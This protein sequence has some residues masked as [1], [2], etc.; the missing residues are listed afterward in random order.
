MTD[1]SVIIPVYNAE[2]YLDA[3]IESIL[4]QRGVSIE[5]FLVD[6]GS[7]DSSGSIC[8]NYS[9]KYNNI[10]VVHITNSGQSVARNTGLKL[11]HGR[12]VTFTDND[13]K[14]LPEMLSKMVSAGDN[15]NADIICCNYNEIDENGVISHNEST[16]Q[17]YILNH[18]EALV[19]FYS[20]DKIY[21]QC[22]SKLYRRQM[23]VDFHVENDPVRYDEDIIF[24]IKA[25]RVAQTTV[26]VDEPLFL[27]T[28]RTDSVVHSHWRYKKYMDRY[29][30]D[31]IKRLQ[32]TAESVQ[33]ESEQV[34]GWAMV[35]MLMY[36]NQLIGRVAA[37]PEYHSDKRIVGAIHFIRKNKT[38]LNR[39]YGRCG[40]S[41]FG[42]MLIIYLPTW[43][44]MKYRRNKIK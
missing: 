24:N 7:T 32:L 35:H 43:L 9:N 11:A 22:W 38:I 2:K 6:D 37:F 34:K 28:N 19:H 1:V 27:Y 14:M 17:E 23:L 10:S 31:N 4:Q 5:I 33:D 8:D 21:S 41:K 36:Y 26:I 12:Y 30:N 15:H 29:I 40:F 39:Y 44:Y 25:F 13:D 20:K 42:K 16:G 18:E 3:C